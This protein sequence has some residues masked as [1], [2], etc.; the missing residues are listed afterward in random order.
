MNAAVLSICL[1]LLLAAQANPQQ[2]TQSLPVQT[3]SAASESLRQ[4]LANL[5]TT[6]RSNNDKR[7][8]A[9]IKKT[10]M[11]I[12]KESAPG[13]GLA[14]QGDGSI[15]A[16][17]ENLKQSEQALQSMFQQF[18]KRDGTFVIREENHNVAQG[19]QLQWDILD[20]TNAGGDVYSAKWKPSPPADSS[21]GE[22]VA[23]F[24]CYFTFMPRE[25][26]WG[27]LGP[28]VPSNHPLSPSAFMRV[29]GFH[30]PPPCATPP[31]STFAPDPEY[32]DPARRKK[33]QGDTSLELTVEVDGTVHDIEVVRFLDYD[34]D[35]KAV[36]AVNR[37]KFDPA[38]FEGKPV[39]VRIGVDVGFRLY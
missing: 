30:S 28:P 25:S 34:L 2:S 33:L 26:R 35:K 4:F 17:R 31:R 9:L 11:P 24:A 27:I 22:A 12:P 7:L 36:E 8:A 14:H 21:K 3:T 19:D 1:A 20:A 38:L 10:R 5:L 16:Y 15:Q 13:T 32:S 6:A 23:Y 18:A 29:C 37:W 39:P